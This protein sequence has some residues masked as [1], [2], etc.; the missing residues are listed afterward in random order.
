MA[1]TLGHRP[2]LDGLR[3][4]ALLLVFGE[5]VSIP[6]FA[7]GGEVGVAV[8]FA[9]SGFLICNLA[10]EE[11]A[12]TGAMSIRGF[13]LRRVRRLIPALLVAVAFWSLWD[14]RRWRGSVVEH[15]IIAVTYLANLAR[16]NGDALGSLSH[17]WTLAIEEQFYVLLP[18]F[19]VPLWRRP[20]VAVPALVGLAVVVMAWR[21]HLADDEFRVRFATDTRT[22]PMLLGCA[23]AIAV[24]GGWRMRWGWLGWVVILAVT[25]TGDH[26]WTWG[27]A[28]VAVASVGVIDDAYRR[29]G[30]LAW[31]PLVWVGK[32]S[33]ALYLWH[34]PISWANTNPLA[35]AALSAIA[36]ESSWRLVERRW[37]ARRV[38]E[39]EHPDVVGPVDTGVPDHPVG[40]PVS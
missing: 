18:V 8:F 28:A 17:T 31:R 25:A 40:R 16:V 11:I 7:G 36:A 27:L 30:A 9:L 13:Y 23:A 37:L 12:R 24:R 5:H 20:R 6:G 1:E 19:A 14:L 2:G 39:Q 34:V 21:W 38:V 10:G 15:A 22:D 35:V 3:G 26:L 4:V 33:Y 32:R 29:P